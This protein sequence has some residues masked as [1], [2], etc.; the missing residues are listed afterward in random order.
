M[1]YEQLEK[2]PLNPGH[3]PKDRAEDVQLSMQEFLSA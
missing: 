2:A 1:R 3:T